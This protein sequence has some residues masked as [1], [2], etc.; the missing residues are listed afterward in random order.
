MWNSTVTPTALRALLWTTSDVVAQR[1]FDLGPRKPQGTG[2]L[3]GEDR[4]AVA[5]RSA[6]AEPATESSALRT[7]A[8]ASPPPPGT[9]RVDERRPAQDERLEQRVE[10]RLD[11]TEVLAAPAANLTRESSTNRRGTRRVPSSTAVASDRMASS[12]ARRRSP[13]RASSLRSAV[14]A[15]SAATAEP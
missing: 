13:S 3:L 6:L 15:L 10:P 8:T 7:V 1:L 9:R 2:G 12:G 4:P 11:R 14:K 5:D